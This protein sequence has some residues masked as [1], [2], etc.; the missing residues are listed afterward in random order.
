MKQAHKVIAIDGP[1]GSGKSTI[2]K[3]VSKQLD[4]VYLD[5]GALYRSIAWTLDNARIAEDQLADIEKF[6]GKMNLEY[7][8]QEN[9]LVRVN[10]IDLTQKIREH[11][12][13]ELASK[14]SKL[15]VIREF[16]KK[17]QRDI[18]L[19]HPAVLE[20]R[21]I[22]T[23]IFPDAVLKVFLTADPIV[24]ANRRFEQLK[25]LGQDVSKTSV[26]QIAK[27]IQ[28]RDNQDQNRKHAP[29]VKAKD[30]VE[31]DTSQITIEQVVTQIVNLFEQ[32]KDQF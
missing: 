10:S 11:H 15:P 8:P 26:E 6:L 19:I 28:E 21:D 17:T 32:R 30:A 29:L 13:S 14:Y 20:G 25:E 3:I 31:I 24:R 1:S 18:A 9:V 27:D 2:A 5:T 4:L 22:G 12:V 16:L 23:V 7:S